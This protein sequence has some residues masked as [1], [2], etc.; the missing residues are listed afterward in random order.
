M[1]R[2]WYF[3]VIGVLV[4]VGAS[5]YALM[6]TF[7]GN[8]S[9]LP[10]WWTKKEVLLGLDLAGGLYLEYHVDIDEAIEDKVE[11]VGDDIRQRVLEKL[12]KKYNRDASDEC[13]D[14]LKFD[15][16]GPE[17]YFT[18]VKDPSDASMA[19]S[20]WALKGYRSKREPIIEVVSSNKSTGKVHIRIDS[21]YA[22]KL[23]DYCLRQGLETI[24]DR[25]DKFGVSGASVMRREDRIIVELPGL[26]PAYVDRVKANLAK[27]AK[28]EFKIV[29]DGSDYMR[30]AWRFLYQMK[31]PKERAKLKP[32]EISRY[33]VRDAKTNKYKWK[34]GFEGISDIKAKTEFGSAPKGREHKTVAYLVHRSRRII[35]KFFESLPPRLK[36]P[37]DRE[38]GYEQEAIKGKDGRPTGEQIWRTYYLYRIAR[39]TGEYLDDADVGYDQYGKPQVDFKFGR[40]GERKFRAL[41]RK[42]IGRRMAVILDKTVKSAPVI[43]S[44]IGARGRIT[45]GGGL[46]SPKQLMQEAKDLVAVLKAGSLPAPMRSEMELLVGPQLGQD[47]IRTGIWSIIIGGLLVV[48]FM[49]AYYRFSGL[50][51]DLALV[52]NVLFILAILAGF[53]AR[54]TLPGMAGIVLTIGMAVDANVIIFERIREELRAGKKPRAAIESGYDRAFWTIMDAQLTTA[55]AAVVLMQYGSGP[56]K[57]FA[58]TLLVGILCSVFTAVWVTRIIF[59]YLSQRTKLERLSI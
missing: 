34:P 58:V 15:V 18:F 21:D 38:V 48:F 51:A 54:L 42:N 8:T 3:K 40:A 26:S 20:S 46:K 35:E 5:V 7:I 28:L 9:K 50:V 44:E 4:L 59:D 55:I 22:K 57:G 11:R 36:F 12:R 37:S 10:K 24:R 29:D 53:E 19:S 52:L 14:L 16:S 6:P 13:T 1:D 56:I 41:T 45:L 30:E 49:L 23:E 39:V 2:K 31:T 47:S 33:M 25:V 32:D 43:Q 17:M 27:T